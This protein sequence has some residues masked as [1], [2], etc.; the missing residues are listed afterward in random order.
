MYVKYYYGSKSQT[1]KK[2]TQKIIS[3]FSSLPTYSHSFFFL[4][5]SYQTFLPNQT[6]LF[7]FSFI[8]PVFLLHTCADMYVNPYTSSFSH[9][10]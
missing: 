9:K 2:I 10:G 4:Q 1:Y 3:P 5:L 6:N 8:F 7:S